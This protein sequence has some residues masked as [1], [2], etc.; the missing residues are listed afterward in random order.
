MLFG[1][2]ETPETG[3]ALTSVLLDPVSVCRISMAKGM[4]RAKKAADAAAAPKKK[5][6]KRAKAMKA[7]KAK[8][9]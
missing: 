4:K 7:M 1:L 5:G 6:G 8:A 3:I 2:K 9:K